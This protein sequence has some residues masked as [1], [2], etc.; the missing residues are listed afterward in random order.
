MTGELSLHARR[1]HERL[2]EAAGRNRKVALADV[3]AVWQNIPAVSTTGPDSRAELRAALDELEL[4]GELR[5]PAGKDLWESIVSPHLPLWVMLAPAERSAP[6][7]AVRRH[8]WH[9]QL[10]GLNRRPMTDDQYTILVKVNAWVVS[11]ATADRPVV[12][13]R[14]RSAEITGD[15]KAFDALVESSLA[16]PGAFTPE[17]VAAE[18]PPFPASTAEVGAG[19]VVL[20]VE[21]QHTFWSVCRV[22]RTATDHRVGWVAYGGGGQASS[23]VRSLPEILRR[24]PGELELVYFGDVDP[25]GL[26]LARHACDAAT[27]AGFASARPAAALYDRLLTVGVAAAGRETIDD[28][29]ATELVSVL[30]ERWQEPARDLLL[31][32]VRVA[33]EQLTFE[34]LSRD[35]DWI[36]RSR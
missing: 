1:L 16:G 29:V 33:Q 17:V 8:P 12:P 3:R 32:T 24:P 34:M 7:V 28:T 21:N 4:H 10:A 5:L 23:A 11:N 6:R 20:M 31:R 30:P 35:R 14:E 36:D 2:R 13:L 9:P 15:E 26:W 22:L 25:K 27:S 18:L 19:A